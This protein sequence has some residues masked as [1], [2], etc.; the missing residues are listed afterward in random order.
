MKTEKKKH[1]QTPGHVKRR[2]LG[3][4]AHLS[5][6]SMPIL[7]WLVLPARSLGE[8]KDPPTSHFNSLMGRYG[9]WELAVVVWWYLGMWWGCGNHGV[10]GVGTGGSRRLFKSKKCQ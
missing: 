9:S 4:S 8:G 1:T 6:V 3:V 5:A 2:V 10:C 7:R